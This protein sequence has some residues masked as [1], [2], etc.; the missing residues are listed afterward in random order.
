MNE[1]SPQNNALKLVVFR[2]NDEHSFYG[3]NVSKTSEIQRAKLFKISEIPWAN[4]FI[5]GFVYIRNHPVSLVN[6]PRWLKTE[7]SEQEEG[8]KYSADD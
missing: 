3:I 2:I 7:M 6:L 8:R 5:E 4:E 1:N